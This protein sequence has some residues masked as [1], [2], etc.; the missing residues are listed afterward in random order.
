MRHNR[1]KFVQLFFVMEK[2]YESATIG[3]DIDY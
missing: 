3:L 2:S 1:I